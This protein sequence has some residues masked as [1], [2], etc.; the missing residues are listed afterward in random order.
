[1]PKRAKPPRKA[2][3][4]GEAGARYAAFKAKWEARRVDPNFTGG[5]DWL[6]NKPELALDATPFVQ[7]LRM[8]GR[9]T[10]DHRF[11]DLRNWLVQSGLIDLATGHW[12]RY[13]GTLANPLARE[14]CEMIEELI[15]GG[16]SER[17]A[18]AEAVAEFAV[19]GNS[20]ESACKAVKRVLDEYRKS[21]RQNPT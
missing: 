3:R 2:G 13:G 4:G 15:A 9:V 19:S 8:L 20:F 12:T 18:I 10:Q 6:I 21:V 5:G 16:T 1:M 11:D 14:T 7:T 17:L